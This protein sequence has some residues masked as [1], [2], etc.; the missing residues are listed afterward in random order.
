MST[1]SVGAVYSPFFGKKEVAMVVDVAPL[2]RGEVNRIEIDYTLSVEQIDGVS[3]EKDAHVVG[4]LTDN[5]GY[6]RLK[7]TAELNLC[8]H[9]TAPVLQQA[10]CFPH[11]LSRTSLLTVA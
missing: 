9:S 10:A 7:L 2:L 5:A 8:T 4:Y 11:L 6:M 3:F 1:K